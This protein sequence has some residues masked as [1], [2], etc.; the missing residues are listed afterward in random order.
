MGFGEIQ[1]DGVTA[2]EVADDTIDGG[3]LINQSIGSADLA[4]NAI[5][6]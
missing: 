3:E 2:S 6:A 4:T 1:T 5:T